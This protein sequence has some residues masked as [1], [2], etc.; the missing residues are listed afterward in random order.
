[1]TTPAVPTI[2]DLDVVRWRY[3]CLLNAGWPAEIA[4]DLAERVD[5]DLHQAVELLQQGA[6]VDE[7]VRILT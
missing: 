6:S 5:V 3:I 7:A 2:L 1:V 4:I